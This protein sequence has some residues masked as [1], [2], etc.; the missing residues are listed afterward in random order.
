M[1]ETVIEA[2]KMHETLFWVLEPSGT[3]LLP[4]STLPNWR[5]SRGLEELVLLHARKHAR[6][7]PLGHGLAHVH[8]RGE[9]AH[10]AVRDLLRLHT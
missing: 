3:L 6:V 5:G 2:F 7:I 8:L 10:D 9:E 4:P 1:F